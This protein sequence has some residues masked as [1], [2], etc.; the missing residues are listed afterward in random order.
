MRSAFFRTIGR[1]WQGPN[2][3]K[4]P[5]LQNLCIFRGDKK[6]TTQLKFDENIKTRGIMQE[7]K[8]IGVVG[9]GQMGRGIAQVAAM[10][11]HE[12]KLFD[13]KEGRLISRLTL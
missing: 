1:E 9:A 5:T 3:K 4:A 7:I 2:D 12:V 6:R 13:V 11:G 10:T 8:V